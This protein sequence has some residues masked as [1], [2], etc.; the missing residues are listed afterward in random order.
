MMEGGGGGGRTGVCKS[1]WK[2]I[3][4]LI[5]GSWANSGHIASGC[6]WQT[7]GRGCAGKQWGLGS[8]VSVVW[9]H[10]VL[11]CLWV[12][13]QGP[14]TYPHYSFSVW[15]P[16]FFT[17]STFPSLSM[18]LESSMEDCS[19]NTTTRPTSWILHQ[20]LPGFSCRQYCLPPHIHKFE[21]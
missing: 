9:S 7:Q 20:T 18:A 19:A 12:L 21:G 14:C 15:N 8:A 5:W 4:T 3:F 2:E 11:R 17:L 6:R 10:Q 16:I 13:P 1:D